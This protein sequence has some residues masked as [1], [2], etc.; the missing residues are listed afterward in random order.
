MFCYVLIKYVPY[1]T[2]N[3]YF[4]LELERWLSGVIALAAIPE[5][6]ELIPST[7]IAAHN[8]L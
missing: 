2:S 8:C 6:R 1:S 5:D 3:K 7:H 4:Y